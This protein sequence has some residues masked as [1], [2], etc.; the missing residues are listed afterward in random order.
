MAAIL[1]AQRRFNRRGAQKP[2]VAPLS[3]RVWL[4]TQLG[5]F[6][7]GITNIL[8]NE[9]SRFLRKSFKWNRYELSL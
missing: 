6:S 7:S 4:K 3:N 9:G 1:A 5:N 2:N 8:F